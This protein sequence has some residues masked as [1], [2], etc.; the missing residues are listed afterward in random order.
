MA[1]HILSLLLLLSFSS[2]AAFAKSSVIHAVIP[3]GMAVPLLIQEKPGEIEGIIADYSR[4]LFKI[5]KRD[6][7]LSIMTRYRLQENLTKG[8]ID[9]L[10]YVA[11]EWVPDESVYIWSKPL[12][13]KRE[14][15]LGPA[16][17]PKKLEALD[18][19]TIGT[20]LGYVYP[21]LDPLFASKT[22]LREDASSEFANLKKLRNDRIKYVVTD[23]IFLEHYNFLSEEQS[24][25]VGRQR[26]LIQKYVI[27]CILSK[28]GSVKVQDLNRAIDTLKSSG[29]LK[30]IFKNYGVSLH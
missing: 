8:K 20:V 15:L 19:K 17:M 22:L 2:I 16:P 28:K 13:T 23:E 4:A 25:D 10:C 6:G 9:F 3:D 26:L 11:R 7:D 5:L 30:R 29:E 27:S 21:V 18:G 1:S 14:V 12:Y 24:L